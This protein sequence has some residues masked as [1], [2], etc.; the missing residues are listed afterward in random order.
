MEG[1]GS[2][3]AGDT[4]AL[5]VHNAGSDPLQITLI[6]IAG[7][8]YFPG[9]SGAAG[10]FEMLGESSVEA[11]ADGTVLVRFAGSDIEGGNAVTVII[12]A[13]GEIARAQAV[14]GERIG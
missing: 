3:S 2:M 12:E 1:D 6:E 9:T 4:L 10:T 14:I 13:G 7:V 8:F 5:Y 11:G